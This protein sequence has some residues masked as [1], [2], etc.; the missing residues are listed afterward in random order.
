MWVSPMVLARS[1]A[2]LID[3]EPAM[4]SLLHGVLR[5]GS[6]ASALR[7]W[8][9]LPSDALAKT[10]TG[11]ESANM[12]ICGQFHGYTILIWEFSDGSTTHEAGEVLGVPFAE[13]V[14]HLQKISK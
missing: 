6:A 13:I 2:R 4:K 5:H 7:D 12:V 3:E 11:P 1:F 10:G 8:D 14:K 9:A